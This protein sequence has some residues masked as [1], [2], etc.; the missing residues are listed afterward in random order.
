M[1]T[2]AL[3]AQ[4]RR[5]LPA[6]WV[7]VGLLQAPVFYGLV[8][9][10]WNA[11]AYDVSVIIPLLSAYLVWQCRQVLLTASWRGT[12]WGFPLL[13]MAFVLFALGRVDTSLVLI[14]TSLLLSLAG[15]VLLQGGLPMLRLLATPLALL[16][17][18]VPSDAA[19]YR[20]LAEVLQRATTSSV[21]VVLQT[22]GLP[23]V[24]NGV[25]LT[26]PRATLEIT[27]GCSGIRSLATLTAL[28]ATVGATTSMPAAGRW[29]LLLA[30]PLMAIAINVARITLIGI[31]VVFSSVSPEAAHAVSN[32]VAF[33]ASLV[34]LML[35]ARKCAGSSQKQASLEVV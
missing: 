22:L 19:L 28:A 11:A 4:T 8:V 26:L 2:D 30:T 10:W 33:G 1:A 32:W 35:L 27:E 15:A 18:L 3:N 29:W 20:P 24:R 13:A 23:V 12:A 25:L 6:M 5:F 31:T 34:A 21:T 16:L 14:R 17:F 9:R 7:A